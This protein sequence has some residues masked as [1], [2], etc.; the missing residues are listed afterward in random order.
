M[1]QYDTMSI[2][3]VVI[4]IIAIVLAFAVNEGFNNKYDHQE[5]MHCI[6]LKGSWVDNS[7]QFTNGEVK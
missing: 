2:I 1:S 4:V 3:A 7:C 5:R 6:E